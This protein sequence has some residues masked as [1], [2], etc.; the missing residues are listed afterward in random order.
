M[1]RGRGK[2]RE[3]INHRTDMYTCPIDKDMEG[4]NR[5]ENGGI[6]V[7]LSTKKSF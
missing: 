6:S 4:S 2:G 3:E 7:I 1:G 5:K